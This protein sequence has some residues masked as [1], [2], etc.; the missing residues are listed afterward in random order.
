MFRVL[1]LQLCL[2]VVICYGTLQYTLCFKYRLGNNNQT[3]QVDETTKALEGMGWRGRD[4]R[5][6][7][8]KPNLRNLTVPPAAVLLNNKR[9][10]TALSRIFPKLNFSKGFFCI[11]LILP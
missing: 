9:S 8:F 10:L 5:N 6:F 4:G 7:T 1:C 3:N 2:Y 11:L